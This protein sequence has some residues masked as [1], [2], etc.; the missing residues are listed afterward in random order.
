MT[1]RH[2][3]PYAMGG[4]MGLMMLRMAHEAMISQSG[5]GLAALAGFVA[6]HVVVLLGGGALALWIT[7]FVPRLQ[8]LLQR[9][10]RPS[11]HHIGQMLVTAALAALAAHIYLHGGL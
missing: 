3:M 1:H 6:L 9:M 10:H 11:W 5:L 8:G 7:R 2:W 4:L